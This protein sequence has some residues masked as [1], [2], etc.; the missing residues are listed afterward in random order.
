MRSRLRARE[1]ASQ[2]S[3]CQSGR[4]AGRIRPARRVVLFI[5]A[6]ILFAAAI[7]GGIAVSKLLWL[8]VILALIVFAIGVF[9]G[10]ID[11]P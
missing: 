9:T 10:R 4:R 8:L 11:E 7:A 5:L 6:V 2:R 1:G 3:P